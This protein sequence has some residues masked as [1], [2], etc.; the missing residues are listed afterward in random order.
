MEIK[1]IRGK[2]FKFFRFACLGV[3]VVIV[4]CTKDYFVPVPIPMPHVPVETDSLK[5]SFVSK[6]ITSI[7]DPFWS[8]ADYLRVD[9]VDLSTKN[10][11]G[12]GLLNMTGTY[13]GVS[14]FNGGDS[15]GL[16]LKAAYDSNNVYLYIEWT[17]HSIDASRMSW[18]WNGDSDAL[19]VDSTNGWT[20][21]RNSDM[22]ALA[23]EIQSASSASGS[24]SSVGCA[25][26]CHN[27]EMK[28]ATGAVD[29]W[30]WSLALS[31]PVGIAFDMN[32][33]SDSGLV[34]DQGQ[35][36]FSRNIVTDGDNRSGPAYE[37]DGEAQEITQLNGNDVIL[38][39][40]YFLI[41]KTPFKGNPVAG[42][43]I[44]F[45]DKTGCYHCH[46][47]KGEGHGE[48]D[49]GP[50]FTRPKMNRMSRESIIAYAS[51]ETHTGHTYFN[52]V[53][54]DQRDNLLA[55]IRG[56][57]GVPGYYFLLN[58]LVIL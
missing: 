46:G 38:D 48:I 8:H 20:S 22:L 40:A 26:A 37:W 31:E 17:D 2:M 7:H 51:S 49:N 36:S 53:P 32:A 29:I 28:P 58:N 50:A 41:N 14:S 1:T 39:P 43:S 35:I 16:I 25:A 13:N 11:Y 44:Y 12:D 23:F 57:A 15:T 19:K 4:S 27:G 21:Q 33:N 30:S 55:K 18:L 6:P 5:A 3:L 9:L 42:E 47:N 45:A 52:K 56:F 54:V 24:F 34:Y 10:L